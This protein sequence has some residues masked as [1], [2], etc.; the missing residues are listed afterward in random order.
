MRA[1][2]SL[3]LNQSVEMNFTQHI[4][5]LFNAVPFEICFIAYDCDYFYNKDKG[6]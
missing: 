1:E 2:I 5:S 6:C 4:P 3:A